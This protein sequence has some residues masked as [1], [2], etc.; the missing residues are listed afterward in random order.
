MLVREKIAKMI[1][2]SV[3]LSPLA[4]PGV[5]AH[6]SGD[7]PASSLCIREEVYRWSG[8]QFVS[9]PRP[10]FVLDERCPRTGPLAWQ[11]HRLRILDVVKTIPMLKTPGT[12]SGRSRARQGPKRLVI[13]FERNS[14]FL[15]KAEKK[16]LREFAKALGRGARVK[17]VGY[18]SWPGT[19]AYNLW[20]SRRRAKRVQEQMEIFGV[21][22]VLVRGKGECC[23]LDKRRL[24]PNRRVEIY[25]VKGGGAY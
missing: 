12:V 10:M 16:R 19:R 17:V 3:L 25:A 23:P 21:R 24:A 18:A 1:L 22:C 20:L 4:G 6:A 5:P 9:P 15:A 8:D 11:R 14:S 2:L 7:T 13:H